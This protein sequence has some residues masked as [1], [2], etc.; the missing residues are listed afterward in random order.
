MHSVKMLQHVWGY[1]Q[2]SIEPD[3]HI[4]LKSFFTLSV[5]YYVS[6]HILYSI[7]T[8]KLC[9]IENDLNLNVLYEQ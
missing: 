6:K 2:P 4:F 7:V 9:K 3:S 1:D 5:K 8:N